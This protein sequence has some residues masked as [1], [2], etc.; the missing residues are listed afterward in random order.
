M[1]HFKFWQVLWTDPDKSN[2]LG[3]EETNLKWFIGK[4]EVYLIQV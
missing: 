2:D 4:K 1:E 3:D